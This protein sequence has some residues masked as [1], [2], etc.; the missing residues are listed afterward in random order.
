MTIV[1]YQWSKK[2]RNRLTDPPAA[3]VV[4]KSIIRGFFAFGEKKELKV[5]SKQP[6]RSRLW[7]GNGDGNNTDS[8]YYYDL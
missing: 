8:K 2:I 7:F 1:F 4:Q 3:K 6:K 5:P